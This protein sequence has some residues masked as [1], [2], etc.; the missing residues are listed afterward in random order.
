MMAGLMALLA[1]MLILS[2][3]A[4][5]AWEE[6]LRRDNE[7][8]MIFRG[9]EIARAIARYRVDHNSI[10]PPSLGNL[11]EPGPRGQYYL[12]HE[13]RDPLVK[14]GVWG[15]LFDGPDGTIVDPA[16]LVHPERNLGFDDA[17]GGSRFERDRQAKPDEP[18]EKAWNEDLEANRNPQMRDSRQ[19]HGLGQR[20]AGVKSLAT[21]KPFRIYKGREG[22]SQWHF[23]YQDYQLQPPGQPPGQPPTSPLTNPKGPNPS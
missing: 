11:M 8:E 6:V 3:V 10:G 7:A 14:D 13:Y 15:L 17:F 1:I 2:T 16:G 23:T 9:Q 19:I 22:Y 20:I 21:G 18:K 12:R 4:F 5:Q